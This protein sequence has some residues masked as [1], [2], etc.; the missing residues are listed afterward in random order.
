MQETK[1]VVSTFETAGDLY[2]EALQQED[3]TIRGDALGAWYATTT[4]TA[5]I[6]EVWESSDEE[7]REGANL[8]WEKVSARALELVKKP[9][10]AWGIFDLS[11][12]GS[13]NLAAFERVLEF[14]EHKE[15]VKSVM[16][17]LTEIGPDLSL[18]ECYL[19]L[20]LRARELPIFS[21]DKE[22]SYLI[23]FDLESS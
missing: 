6:L 11:T 9:A 7:D 13:P 17:K 23:D 21:E 15:H 16:A 8:T 10:D 14:C 2:D 18:E 3:L 12:I 20:F 1:R 19:K 5:E 4:T 22:G